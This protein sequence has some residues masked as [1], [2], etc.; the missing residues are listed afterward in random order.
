MPGTVAESPCLRNAV[1]QS[2]VDEYIGRYLEEVGQRLQLLT[3]GA[4]A[5]GLTGRL[6]EQ[7]TEAWRGFQEGIDRLTAYLAEH[8]PDAY[9]AIV[10][11]SYS[12]EATPDDFVAGCVKAYRANFDPGALEA[13]IARLDAQHTELTEQWRDLPTPL[14]RKKAGQAVRLG[15]A[16]QRFQEQDE[17]FCEHFRRPVLEQPVTLANAGFMPSSWLAKNGFVAGSD[18]FVAAVPNE[19]K[20]C[21]TRFGDCHALKRDAYFGARLAKMRCSVRRCMLSRRA[22]SETLRLHIS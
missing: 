22:V 10:E 1:K 3:Q 14:A 6:K 19:T 18:Y 11:D 15:M 21:V 9:A 16:P 4:G 17:L 7:E 13:E 2:V 20:S 8:H 12:D 5:G